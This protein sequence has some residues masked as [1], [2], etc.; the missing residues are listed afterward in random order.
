MEEKEVKVVSEKPE[1]KK[2]SF[3]EPEMMVIML[4]ADDIIMT[5]MAE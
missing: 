2:E 1:E 5:S 4:D 3:E